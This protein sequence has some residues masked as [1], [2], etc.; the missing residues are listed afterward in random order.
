MV[1]YNAGSGVQ[2]LTDNFYQELPVITGFDAILTPENY[3]DAPG[4]WVVVVA[5]VLRSTEAV[6][7]GKY[8]Q[9]NIAGASAVAAISNIVGHLGFPFTF[10]GDGMTA[11]LPPDTAETALGAL[12]DLQSTIWRAFEIELRVGAI[13]VDELRAE[14]HE[15]RIGKL[16]V[17]EKY[18]QAVFDGAGIAHAEERVKGGGVPAG[19]PRTTERETAAQSNGEIRADTEGFS[20]RWRAI[21]SGPGETVS[22]IVEAVSSDPRARASVS[23]EVLIAIRES[24]GDETQYHPVAAGPQRAVEHLTEIDNEALLHARGRGGFALARQR[25]WIWV[26]L[27]AVQFALRWNIPLRYRYKALN[28]IPRDNIN[29]A[30]FRKYDGRLKMVLACTADGRRVLEHRLDELERAGKIV[31][32][33]HISDHALITCIMHLRAPDEV[34]FIDGGDGGYTLAAAELKRKRKEQSSDR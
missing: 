32:G 10:G 33:L 8:K 11:V 25:A 2:V 21:P 34:H 29:H 27:I 31:Y 1:W 28:E 30:D 20:C 18:T 24:L 3:A 16:R 23:R 6:A 9:V 19:T 22:L 12:R 5:D 4:D 26:Q 14:R 7:A 13:T 15:V 17:S